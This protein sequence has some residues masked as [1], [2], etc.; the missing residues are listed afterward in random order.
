MSPYYSTVYHDAF[1]IR[2]FGYFLEKLKSIE[3]GRGTLLDHC[4]VMYGSEL[5]DASARPNTRARALGHARARDALVGCDGVC[6]Y[7]D[8][9]AYC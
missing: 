6:G 9:S 3:D 1:H 2:Q 4:M 8:L 5:G 7:R